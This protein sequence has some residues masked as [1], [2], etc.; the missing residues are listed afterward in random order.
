LLTELD[1]DADLDAKPDLLT[2]G[3]TV[4]DNE[5]L[6]EFE[7]DNEPILDLDCE[8]DAVKDRDL[9]LLTEY[10]GDKVVVLEIAAVAEGPI[11]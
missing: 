1:K 5:V 7:L 2:L 3:S 11:G 10:I 4:S 9:M 6:A 8:G